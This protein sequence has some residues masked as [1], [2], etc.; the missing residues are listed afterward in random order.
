MNFAL[1]CF[2]I[3]QLLLENGYFYKNTLYRSLRLLKLRKLGSILS[4]CDLTD[5][6]LETSIQRMIKSNEEM[7]IIKLGAATADVGGAACKAAVDS[8]VEEWQVARKGV[9]AMYQYI[10]CTY[11]F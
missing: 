5:V 9:E 8:G 6:G 10:R 7:E 11:A 2:Q 4:D 3:K 1:P